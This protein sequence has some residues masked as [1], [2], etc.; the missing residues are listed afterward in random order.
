MSRC[1]HYLAKQS[2]F[3]TVGRQSRQQTNTYHITCVHKQHSHNLYSYLGSFCKIDY[4]YQHY[5][6]KQTIFFTLSRQSR[7]QTH[8]TLHYLF[9]QAVFRQTFIS[10]F[11]LITFKH[12]QQYCVNKQRSHILTFLILNHFPS[13][14][15]VG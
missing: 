10:L 9:S 8:G 7:Q 5:L 1:Q 13:P 11:D 6:A 12:I 3:F 15:S 2:I 14:V 4:R